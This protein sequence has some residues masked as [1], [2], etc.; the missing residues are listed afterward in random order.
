VSDWQAVRS[1]DTVAEMHTIDYGS[2]TA[3]YASTFKPGDVVRNTKTLQERVV[4][5]HRADLGL[6]EFEDSN[7]VGWSDAQGWVRKAD[8]PAQ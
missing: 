8:L 6:L 3:Q 2:H 5:S 7:L 4:V 1:K